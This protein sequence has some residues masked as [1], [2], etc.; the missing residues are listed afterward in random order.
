MT[1]VE[2]MSATLGDAWIDLKTGKGVG[3][4]ECSVN[5]LRLERGKIAFDIQSP[6]KR[7]VFT[8]RF[9]GVDPSQRYRIVWN[10]RSSDEISGRDLIAN[11]YRVGP[12]L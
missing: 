11:G 4:D 3:F 1:S 5:N 12:L 10:G 2:I 9:R 6:A 7:R 8:V